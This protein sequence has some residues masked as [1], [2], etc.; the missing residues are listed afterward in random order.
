MRTG[1]SDRCM[2]F[3]LIAAVATITVRRAII[4]RRT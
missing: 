1:R 3:P 4:R 2:L